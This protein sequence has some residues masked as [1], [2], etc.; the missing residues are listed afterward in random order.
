MRQWQIDHEKQDNQRFEKAFATITKLAS[1]EDV[2]VA[3]KEAVE[4]QINGNLREINRQLADLKPVSLAKNWLWE[5]GKIILY[6]GALAMASYYI[7]RVF[8]L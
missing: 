2:V 3:V 4:T 7:M 5:A 6:I 8:N 1:K